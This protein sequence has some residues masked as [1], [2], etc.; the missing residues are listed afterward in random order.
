MRGDTVREAQC[1]ERAALLKLAVDEHCWDGGWYVRAFFD[2]GEKMG[3]HTSSECAIDLLPQ[4]FAVLSGMPCGERVG[5]AM[6]NAYNRLVDK[7]LRLVRLFDPPFQH[8][9][10][11]PGYV[12]AYPSGLRENG[13]QYTHAAIWFAI[14]L[15][16]SGRVQDGAEILTMLNPANRALDAGLAKQYK[17]EPYYMAADIYTNQN[18][19]G[20]G[21]WSM[22]TG[23][24]SWYYRAVIET[25][26]GLCVAGDR[27]TFRPNLPPEWAGARLDLT[28]SGTKLS[29]AIIQSGRRRL[30]CGGKEAEFI[31]LDG[32]EYNVE[33]HV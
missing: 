30:L 5:Q 7:K 3:S 27:V 17:L 29:V 10:Q 24:S 19:P 21:G 20:R 23:A 2:N 22:Y 25:L 18:A 15:I 33:V 6:D 31:A 16:K 1:A 26:L 14:A 13:G 32:G 11:Q 12:K 9:H 8:S 28:L 4:S